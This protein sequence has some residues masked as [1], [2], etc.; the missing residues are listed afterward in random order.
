MTIRLLGL[1]LECPGTT[2]VTLR[3]TLQVISAPIHSLSVF[4]FDRSVTSLSQDMFMAGV[5]IKHLQ[6]SHSHL[7]M[8]KDNSLKNLR[9]TLESLSIVNGKLLQVPK[10]ALTGMQKLMM[11]DFESN[12]ITNLPDYSFYGL[13]LVKLNM[14]GNLLENI[15]EFAFAGPE[16]SITEIDLS[17]NKIKSFPMSAL[18]KLE[19]LR[20]LR[21]SFNEIS[22]LYGYP[23][24]TRFT[25][26]IFL[27]LSSNKFE[28]IKEDSFCSFPYLKTLSLYNNKIETIHENAFN[29]LRE[30]QSLDI[31]H[32]RVVYL[33]AGTF[34]MTRKLQTIDLSH[35]HV[36]YISGLF[37]NLLQL[38]E[39]F[40]SENNILFVP[41]D[42]FTNSSKISVIYLED[43]A[44]QRLDVNVFNTL[45]G[46]EQL[47]LSS[48]FLRQI[49]RTLFHK[50][51]KLTSLSLDR[52]Y[53]MAL[54][55]GTF[56]HSESLR[57]IRL[58]NNQIQQI[59]Q[60][61][62][63]PLPALLELHVQN[64]LIN[65]IET[66][67]FTS[68]K[69]LQ[70]INLQ[71]NQLKTLN[72]IFLHNST[73]LLSIQLNANNIVHLHNESFKGLRNVQI[74]WL[75]NNRLN[76]L[77][78]TMFKDLQ[79]VERIYLT[80]NSITT[81]QL[82][83]FQNMKRLSSLDLS[84]NKL[85]MIKKDFFSHLSGLEELNLSSNEINDIQSNS[86]ANLRKLK[87]LD[88]SNN[89]LLT[90]NS[91]IFQHDLPIVMLNMKNCSLSKIDAGTFRAL[92]NL[93]DI[94]ME[95]NRLT[96]ADIKQL[97]IPSLR[98]L[99]ISNN[100]F[101]TF[102]ENVFDKLPSLQTLIMENCS[103]QY[104]DE[105]VFRKNINLVK[106]ELG[107]NRLKT[108]S[109]N[110]FNG[111][112]VFKELKLNNNFLS[113]FPHIALYNISTL[114]SLSLASNSLTN[115]D[116]FKLNGLPYLRNL[117]LKDNSISSL[118][119]FNAVNL[120]QLDFVDLSGNGLVAL[121]S[122]FLQN[123]ITLQRLDLSSNRFHQIPSVALSD[124][125]LPRLGWLN[126]TG[127]PL[128][129]IYGTSGE[130][131]G[132]LRE[133]RISNTNLTLLTSKDFE[134]FNALQ[135]LY[136]VHNRINRISPGAFVPLQ[137]LLTLD[138]S[139][140]EL[141]LLPK[142]RLQGL[143]MLKLLNASHNNLRD[144][145]EF[146]IDLAK[147]Q[148][149]DV[150]FNQLH[151][152]GK[153]VFKHLTELNEL[154]LMGNRITTISTDAFK[155][156][157]SLKVLDLRKNY[158][159]QVPLPALKPLETHIK[160]LRIEDNPLQCT[161]ESQE[162][163][164]WLLD[165]QKWAQDNSIQ[166]LK[167]EQPQELRGS[168]F[169]EMEPKEFCDMPLILKLAI[170]D[171][172]PYSVLVSWQSREHTGL[173]GYHVIYHSL[174]GEGEVLSERLNHLAHSA[175]LIKLSSST[176]YRIC[177]L[178]LGNWI[179]SSSKLYDGNISVNEFNQVDG[180]T[181]LTDGLMKLLMDTSVS[182][183]TEVN[184]IDPTPSLITDENGLSSH[185]IIHSLLTRRLGLIVGCCMGII[186]FIV[187]ISVLGYLKLKKRRL[188]N[189]KRQQLPMPPEY[190]SY[191]HFSIPQEEMN[192]DGCNHPSFISGTVMGTTTVSC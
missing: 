100:N 24:Q 60:N 153:Y 89:L 50:C 183:C 97:D 64:N 176:R 73:S 122:N 10:K 159:E 91:G 18:K 22:L 20:S 85:R 56:Q 34:Q 48:N 51:R 33:D 177:V 15:S 54:E 155:Y 71:N 62:F 12:E 132:F 113:D 156:V 36:H 47:Y 186:V 26:L 99:R 115:V 178:G 63:Y 144:V 137:N 172:Q 55:P 16:E 181:A 139:I 142:E 152:I 23:G 170:Q 138:L 105:N 157:K 84:C 184:T 9:E 127:N 30:L 68:L 44:I 82:D 145:E 133:I 125:L 19:H 79:H 166:Q 188:E 8:L 13:R 146:T 134:A 185:G 140:N 95:N 187:L 112:N 78:K 136:L 148:I 59:Q 182:R 163:W 88:L 143:K 42:A 93:N 37:S 43:N 52:N 25:S 106:V 135:H 107:N 179:S 69:A 123:A 14:K 11:L 102:I 75:E 76:K 104:L 4:D 86:F 49:P 180:N 164:E 116:F 66:H 35:N 192:R 27:D 29:S 7:Q 94:N 103:I 2:A 101:S 110:I 32:N 168:V 162:L 118:S 31:S 149:L 17:E 128:N 191:R 169:T 124:T 41:V 40:L 57:E 121:P 147:L 53:I 65:S 171:I 158:F 98:T 160:S 174:D 81:I 175:K 120:T 151:R 154:H 190:I 45:I 131:Y 87:N 72:D 167:C 141:E 70:H 67:A 96:L 83:T 92:N 173:H 161:C 74:L 28:E 46:L 129:Q 77:D 114:E 165:H 1:F 5:H 3:S 80:N 61:V 126:L 39:V 108:I 150:S 109:R 117:I 130:R 90:L 119:G 21:L 6:F 189:S 58:H 38:R 111:L